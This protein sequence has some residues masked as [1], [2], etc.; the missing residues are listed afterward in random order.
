[1]E[2]SRELPCLDVPRFHLQ[3][4]CLRPELTFSLP[5][6]K[7]NG[8]KHPES[9]SN[10]LTQSPGAEAA[11]PSLDV[12]FCSDLP[13]FSKLHL[14]V[15]QLQLRE[16]KQHHPTLGGKTIHKQDIWP[17]TV[18]YLPIFHPRGI[19]VSTAELREKK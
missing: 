3:I 9:R 14:L 2:Q 5:V 17:H 15:Q 13:R 6:G 4:T 10:H 7:G 19:Q 12:W 16:P 18:L 11:S 1:M 8:E